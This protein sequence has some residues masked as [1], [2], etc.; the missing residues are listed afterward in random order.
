MST[1]VIRDPILGELRF[2]AGASFYGDVLAGSALLTPKHLVSVYLYVQSADGESL[3]AS[4]QAAARLFA[5]VRRCEW[6][7]RFAFALALLDAS[8]LPSGAF[9]PD[10]VARSLIL[11]EVNFVE[12]EGRAYLS[13]ESPAGTTLEGEVSVD[14]DLTFRVNLFPQG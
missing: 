7:Y 13:Y 14:D 4:V 1:V 2:P 3:A 8:L 9:D 6:E 12:S 10:A 5:H 11:S